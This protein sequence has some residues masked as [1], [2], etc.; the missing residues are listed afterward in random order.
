MASNTQVIVNLQRNHMVDA[1]E[2]S[3][4]TNILNCVVLILL[5]RD[6]S[7]LNTFKILITSL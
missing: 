6:T 7:M 4:G 2:F 5:N 1:S 3:N